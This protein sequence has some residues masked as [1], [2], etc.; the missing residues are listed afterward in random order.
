M[1]LE[2]GKLSCS[3]E[4]IV[5]VEED[6][7]TSLS[8]INMIMPKR[9][10][11]SCYDTSETMIE[12]G[13]LYNTYCENGYQAHACGCENDRAT[14]TYDGF[15][16]DVYK[17]NPITTSFLRDKSHLNPVIVVNFS[18]PIVPG[19]CR[20]VRINFVIQSALETLFPNTFAFKASYFDIH[21]LELPREELNF[22]ELEIPVLKM[23]DEATRQGGFDMFLYIRDKLDAK[24]FNY[25]SL[26]LTG[27]MPDG[28]HSSTKFPRFM[29]RARLFD[30]IRDSLTLKCGVTPMTLVGFLQTPV[31]IDDITNMKLDILKIEKG[32]QISLRIGI[33]AVIFA[34]LTWLLPIDR[35]I[36][37]FES[38]KST[39]PAQEKHFPQPIAPEVKPKVP[40]DAKG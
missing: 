9:E 18:E 10:I 7:P 23:Y 36:G 34:A 8:A 27:N 28:T 3:R 13:Y 12:K 25:H 16:C 17:K 40:D 33:G 2:D 32:G 21:R 29:W 37:W 5:K 19:K 38:T 22:E 20:A 30:N 1:W 39:L 6:S 11:T 14:I 26:A 35:I 31:P 15:E 24:D 4:I